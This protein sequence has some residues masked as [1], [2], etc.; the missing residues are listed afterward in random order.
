MSDKEKLTIDQRIEIASL[1]TQL[2]TSMMLSTKGTR[3]MMDTGF[4]VYPV[5]P[6]DFQTAY[7]QMTEIIC[8][9]Q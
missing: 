4:P 8:A 9:D 6:E 2:M 1:V 5:Y 3:T 7:E